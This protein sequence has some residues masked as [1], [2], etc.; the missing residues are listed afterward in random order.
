MENA[1]EFDV[2]HCWSLLCFWFVRLGVFGKP[3]LG[4]FRNARIENRRQSPNLP[5]KGFQGVRLIRRFIGGKFPPNDF[6]AFQ[7]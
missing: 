1:V 3:R 4:F 6:G 7:D 2:V 5:V